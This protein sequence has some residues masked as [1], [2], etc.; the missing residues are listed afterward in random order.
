LKARTVVFVTANLRCCSAAN[1]APSDRMDSF[2]SKLPEILAAMLA[3]VRAG[4]ID[5]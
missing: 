2:F 4:L 5:R 3:L 1:V